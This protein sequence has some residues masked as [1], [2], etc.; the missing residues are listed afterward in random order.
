[1]TGLVDSQTPT[2]RRTLMVY[3][4]DGMSKFIWLT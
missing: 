2:V 4:I 3:V 1:M